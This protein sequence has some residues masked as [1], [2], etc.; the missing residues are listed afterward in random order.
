MGAGQGRNVQVSE[1]ALDTDLGLGFDQA[2]IGMALVGLDGRLLRVNQALCQLLG[3]GE[4]ELLGM[5]VA[6]LTG[7]EG[8]SEL[9]EWLARA[10]SQ[11]PSSFRTE[12]RGRRPDGAELELGIGVTV[13][14]DQSGRPLGFFAQLQDLT[15][16]NRA[17]RALRVSELWLRSVVANAPIVLSVYDR[18]G[19][20]TFAEGRAFERLGITPSERV[21]RSFVELRGDL[22]EAAADFRRL[23][24]GEGFSAKRPVGDRVFDVHYRPLTEPDGAVGG[25]VSVAVDVTDLER[26]ERDRRNLLRQLI[27]AQEEERRR[28]AGDLHDD[29]IQS[30]TAARMHLSVL[31]HQLGR[32]APA[33]ADAVR[34]QLAPA[35]ESL[36]NGLRAARTFLFNLRP[37]LLD[38]AGLQA[39]LR[40][41]LDKLA[42]RTG[43][44]SELIWELDGRLDRELEAVAFRVAQEALANAARHAGAATVRVRGG[45]DGPA[46]LLEIAD[47]GVG[48]DPVAARE[49]ALATGHLGLRSMAERV[50]TAGGWLEIDAAPG[51][52][53]RVVLRLPGPTA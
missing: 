30:L 35:R 42:E 7:V 4:D 44:A 25:V 21:G 22:P 34:R 23:L 18:N 40:Q 53:A 9:A 36:D 29:A 38:S 19:I 6:E 41:Q 13:L 45:W 28:L 10:A 20:C 32:L 52:G 37:P 43:W 31:D 2:A 1:P 33:A 24:A 26:V 47:D 51:R 50:E 14:R 8:L 48:F 17:A 3:S 49:R 27:T 46:V 12:R 39:A 5:G 15:E 16:R 11:G